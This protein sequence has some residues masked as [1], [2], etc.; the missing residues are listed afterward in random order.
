LIIP[1]IW[2]VIKF[3]GSKPP[4]RY[5]NDVLEAGPFAPKPVRPTGVLEEQETVD[6]NACFTIALNRELVLGTN[7][8]QL[9]LEGKPRAD[10]LA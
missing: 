6:F 5:T 7:R 9:W 8:K 1:N 4:T 10:L 3:H 2:K